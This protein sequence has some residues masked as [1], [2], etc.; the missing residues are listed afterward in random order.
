MEL[1]S[2]DCQ[3]C[4]SR[5]LGKSSSRD[6]QDGLSPFPKALSALL[7]ITLT[8]ELDLLH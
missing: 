4:K 8:V 1:V 7:S 3:D 5:M 6:E 2:L